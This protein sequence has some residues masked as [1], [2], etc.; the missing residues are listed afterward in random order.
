MGIILTARFGFP[1][2]SLPSR[3]AEKWADDMK[4]NATRIND[5][6]IIAIPDETAFNTKM[7]APS[8]TRWA[9][10]ITGI[11]PNPR[12][13]KLSTDVYDNQKINLLRSFGKYADKLDEA[14]KT[15]GTVV[16]QKFCNAVDAAKGLFADGASARTIRATG[17]RL[18]GVGAAVLAP[19][20]LTNHPDAM[21]KVRQ[22]IDEVPVGG[23]FD[24]VAAGYEDMFMR[25]LVA[26]LTFALIQAD[27]SLLDTTR[28]ASLNDRLN[29]ICQSHLDLSK[30]LDPFSTGGLTHVN[31]IND[32]HKGEMV[33]VQLNVV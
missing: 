17:T 16:A 14:F 26:E 4:I 31:I 8:S 3:S 5:G 1:L 18:E 7:A 24:I 33:E 12:K 25:L 28:L 22:G 19:M 9:A 23:P 21:A 32:P 20:F 13:A 30:G 2:G 6:R 15:V 10:T 27:K 11:T 29:N